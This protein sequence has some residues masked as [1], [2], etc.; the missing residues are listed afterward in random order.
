MPRTPQIPPSDI[1]LMEQA[2]KAGLLISVEG[3]DDGEILVEKTRYSLRGKIEKMLGDLDEAILRFY[4]PDGEY[5]GFAL[6]MYEYG[7]RND[8]II[9]DYST[10]EWVSTVMAD[11]YKKYVNS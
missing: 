10:T 5:K 8:E 7:Q 1:Y 9:S 4:T 6:I 11:Y 3:S 2:K